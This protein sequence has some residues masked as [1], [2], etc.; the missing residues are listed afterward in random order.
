MENMEDDTANALAPL[1]TVGLVNAPL[2]L[3]EL[4][5][6]AMGTLAIVLW[7]DSP[8]LVWAAVMV[9]AIAKP[10]LVETGRDVV[11]MRWQ[12]GRPRRSGALAARREQFGVAQRRAS[13]V[14]PLP[15]TAP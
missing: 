6:I 4:S 10:R 9:L 13:M 2:P 14:V 1:P 8:A 11:L 12:R 5:A 3:L 7:L 15:P